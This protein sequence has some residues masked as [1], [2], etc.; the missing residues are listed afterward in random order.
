MLNVERELATLRK[1]SVSQL[2]ARYAEVWGE[3]T[4]THHR[5]W[6]IR[7]VIWRLQ[8]LEQ[9]DLSER[10]RRR[11]EEIAN[12]ADLRRRPPKESPV[13]SQ[14]KILKMPVPQGS[15]LPPPGSVIERQ[16]KGANLQVA[17]L[18]DGQFEFQGERYKSLSAVA[19]KISG[20][21]CNG[22]HFF[23]LGSPK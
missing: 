18:A 10:A 2:K 20:S 1:M 22:F 4:N 6:L 15:R 16:Y 13:Q 11:A 12:D 19:K 3:T 7:R 5:T 9:G 14:S 21:H 8:C 17:I 23:R